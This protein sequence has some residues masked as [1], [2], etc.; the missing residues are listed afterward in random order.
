MGIGHAIANKFDKHGYEVCVADIDQDALNR[1]P[2]NW[3]KFHVDVSDE[4]A[5]RELFNNLMQDWTHIDVLCANAGIP[6]PTAPIEAI[7][8]D[9][10]RKCLAVNLDGTFLFAKYTTPIMKQQQ[11]GLCILISSTAGLYGFM[12][13]APYVASKWAVIGLMKTLAIELGPYN[14]RANAICPGSVAGD[15]LD[16]VIDRE[17]NAK[18]VT[19]ATIRNAYIAGT[20]LRKPITSDDVA[21]MAKF[22][23][24]DDAHLISGQIIAIDGNTEHPEPKFL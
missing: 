13:R 3:H 7:E 9:D 19:P 5:V 16:L 15:R 22:L 24:S 11:S 14:V 17:A 10:W 6:G 18:G 4:S 20:S 2:N 12:N 21:N 8:M 23:A 1:C